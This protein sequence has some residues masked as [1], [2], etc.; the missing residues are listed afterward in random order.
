MKTEDNSSAA[1]YASALLQIGE[2]KGTADTML[3]SITDVNV[4]F[5]NDPRLSVFLKHP[6]VPSSEKQAML[7]EVFAGLVDDITAK[8]LE[9]LCERRRMH[10]LPRIETHFLALLQAKHNVAPATLVCAEELSDSNLEKFSL[11]LSQSIGKKLDLQVKTDRS[12]IAGYILKVGDQ[13]IDGSIKG[14]LQAV[15]K[16]LLSV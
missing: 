9:V 8:L 6:G 15:E 1:Q 13:V 14:R 11:R 16:A 2:S 12:L 3:K 4:V 10:L 7:K 5:G